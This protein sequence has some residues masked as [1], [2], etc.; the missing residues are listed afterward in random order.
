MSSTKV[1]KK[2]TSYHLK[3]FTKPATKFSKE[4]LGLASPL[5]R[6]EKGWLTANLKKN[7]FKWRIGKGKV[8]SDL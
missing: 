3:A 2:G 1:D 7:P 8:N 4:Y 5:A 6:R